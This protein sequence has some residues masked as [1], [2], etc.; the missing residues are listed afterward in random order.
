MV[1]TSISIAG[2]RLLDYEF[3]HVTLSQSIGAHHFF[4]IRLRQDP[5]SG[6]LPKQVSAWIG[7]PLALGF[8]YK[9]DDPLMMSQLPDVFKGIITSVGLTRQRGTGELVIQGQSPTTAADDGPNT[10]SFTDK[11]LQEIVN[12][13]LNPYKGKFPSGPKVSPKVFTESL[14]YTVQYKESAFS[15]IARMANRF[16]E[17]FYYDG[18]D[19]FFGKPSGGDSVVLDFGENAMSYFD[20]TARA[21]PI[22]FELEAYDYEKHPEPLKE[23]APE[24]APQSSLGKTTMGLATGKIYSEKPL[25][26]VNFDLKKKDLK[27]I[28]KRR[29]EVSVDEIIVMHGTTRNPKLKLGGKISVK[30]TQLGETYG[31]YVITSLTHDIGQGGDYMNNFEAIPVEVTTPPLTSIPEPPFCEMQL[32]KVTDVNDEK[33]LGRVKVKF[34]WQEGSPEKTPWIRVA[35]PYTGKDKGFYIIPEVEDQVLIAFENNHPDKPYVL[36]GMYNSD[37]KPEWFDAKNKF[38]GFKSK[39]GNK[40]KFD[41]NNKEVQIHA[42]SSILETAGSKVSIRSGKKKEDSSIVMQEGKEI[43]ISTDGSSDSIIKLDA[44]TGKIHIIA[45]TITLEAS[46][47]IE[48]NSQQK[49]KTEG[50]QKVETKSMEVTVNGTQKVETTGMQVNIK[51]TAMVDVKG[52]MIKLN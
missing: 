17:W 21:V 44:G 7:Q 30:D 46:E 18:L 1:R 33:S 51:G 9:G 39:G 47:L 14:P 25:L 37:A 20:L 49:V 16:G 32:A 4:E 43:T 29:E 41:D 13:V 31:D 36:S 40:W 42:P 10:R 19:L 12:E 45:K 11:G 23:K 52:M 3:T 8:D 5:K 34:K 38:K 6:V 26:P 27:Q 28:A 50:L 22:K 15:F 2:K 35:S 48:L 24:A